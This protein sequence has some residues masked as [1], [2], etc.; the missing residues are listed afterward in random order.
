[1][2]NKFFIVVLFLFLQGVACSS[3]KSHQVD[4]SQ[5]SSAINVKNPAAVKCIN[6]GYEV[7]PV[8]EYGVPIKYLCVNKD[9]GIKCELWSYFRGECDLRNTN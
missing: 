5:T 8:K 2:R 4:N 3:D 1:M 9:T 6:D 7:Q